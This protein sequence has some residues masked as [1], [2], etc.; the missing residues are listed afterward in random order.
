MKKSLH[1]GEFCIGT[2]IDPEE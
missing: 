1:R 2:S